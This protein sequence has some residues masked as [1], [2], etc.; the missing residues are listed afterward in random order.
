[1]IMNQIWGNNGNEQSIMNHYTVIFPI[2]GGAV[3]SHL[4]YGTMLL[5]VC[6]VFLRVGEWYQKPDLRAVSVSLEIHHILITVLLYTFCL[7]ENY[8]MFVHSA[9]IL[10]TH[11]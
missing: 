3:Y 11:S 10:F 7:R 9:G 4:A 2:C 5:L 1:M 8:L 6:G